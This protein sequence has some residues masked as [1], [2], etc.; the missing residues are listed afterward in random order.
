MI[1]TGIALLSCLFHCGFG[2]VAKNAVAIVMSIS[3][4]SNFVCIGDISFMLLI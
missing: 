1:P 2:I 4:F 3:P